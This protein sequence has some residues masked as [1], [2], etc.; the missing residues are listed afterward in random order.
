MTRTGLGNDIQST[1]PDTTIALTRVGIT[2]VQRVIRLNNPKQKSHTLFFATINLFVYLDADKAGAHMSRFISN[3]EDISVKMSAES[4]P[5][6]ETVAERMALAIA[7]TQGAVRSEVSIR[8][9]FPMTRKAPESELSAESLYTYIG[10]AI[11]NGKETKKIIGVEARGLTACPCSREMSAEFSR[12]ILV[13]K[14]YTP[15]QALEITNML[16][17]AAHNQRGTGRLLIGSDS[18]IPAEKLVR[19]VEKSMS[20]EIYPLL[21]RPDERHVVT[22]AH[23]NP[24]FVEDVVREIIKNVIIEFS[25]LPDDTFIK[26]SQEN[27]ESIHPHSA[28]AERCALLG[29]LRAE[30]SGQKTCD[31]KKLTSLDGWF[32]SQLV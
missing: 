22:K 21:K 24:M 16:P 25:N 32:A 31:L 4:A 2:D 19:I 3:M 5:T 28:Y 20:S 26:A 23:M 18:F 12:S 27:L 6:I 1:I 30:V 10:H 17:L 7:K 11:S 13:E 9:Q 15:E 14:G 29:Q 8:A